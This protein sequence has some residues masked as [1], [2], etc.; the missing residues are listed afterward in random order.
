MTNR[1]AMDRADWEPNESTVANALSQLGAPGQGTS[2]DDKALRFADCIRSAA[3]TTVTVARERV[4]KTLWWN[5]NLKIL[6]TRSRD[7]RCA[8]QK[9]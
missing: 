2:V 9:A 4:A 6:K 5:P 7:L 1:W 8:Y 3:S